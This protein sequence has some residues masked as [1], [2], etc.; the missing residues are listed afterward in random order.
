MW[1]KN[2]LI[3][4]YDPNLTIL[5]RFVTKKIN[6]NI[7]TLLLTV[8]L[9]NHRRKFG[10]W[11]HARKSCHRSP[12]NSKI[13]SDKIHLNIVNYQVLK[14]AHG[15]NG[16]RR[17]DLRPLPWWILSITPSY[18]WRIAVSDH[19][20]CLSRIFVRDCWLS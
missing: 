15:W 4:Y 13:G 16:R 12:H 5:D 18:G 2:D 14:F 17:T 8:F 6:K 1:I 11:K 10:K 3:R 7:D 20:K 9:Y 19:I